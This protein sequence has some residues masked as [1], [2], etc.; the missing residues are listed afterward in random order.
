MNIP[1]Q[2]LNL[3][4]AV[5]VIAIVVLGVTL[6]ALPTYG[7][8][9]ATDASTRDVAQ[10]NDIYAMQVAQLSAEEKRIG[11]IDAEVAQLRQQ[12]TDIRKIDDV[13]EI[14]ILAA[15]ANGAAVES[16]TVGD[17][18]AWQPRVD[19]SAE[20]AA[21]QATA[22]DPSAVVEAQD[23][24]PAE[25][26][27]PAEG[28]EE[29]T[30]EEATAEEPV[31]APDGED[32]PQR[33]IPITLEVKVDSAAAAAAFMDSLGAGPRLLAITSGKFDAGTLLVTAYALMR[34]G[35]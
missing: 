35:A 5:V 22:S 9:Q 6:V 20:D 8:A 23:T 24:A 11:E 31:P 19:V 21:D 13:I 30:T 14:V 2:L 25:S 17:V 10:T 15:V 16:V 29:A 26:A 27:E 7:T 3:L 32:S 12:I 18:E 1:R 4:G 33:Q 34:T 28:T